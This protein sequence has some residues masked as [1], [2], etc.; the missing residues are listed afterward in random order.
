MIV[1]WRVT[2]QCN[3]TCPFCAWDRS[4]PGERFQLATDQALRFGT[5]LAQFQAQTRERVLLS[6]LGGETSEQLGLEAS[7]EHRTDARQPGQISSLLPRHRRL[8]RGRDHLQCAGRA[9]QARIL[10]VEFA[11]RPR[12]GNAGNA[13]AAAAVAVG[14]KRRSALRQHR[15]P[16]ENFCQCT[17]GAA[18]KNC[19]PGTSY[20]FINEYGNAAPCKDCPYTRVFSKF[21]V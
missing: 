9:G 8:G 20:L 14:S 11:S 7:R 13:I 19:R 15:I 5:L 12:S 6:W 21:K 16:C 2:Q 3:L 4:V 10:P 17:S 18:G 1:V